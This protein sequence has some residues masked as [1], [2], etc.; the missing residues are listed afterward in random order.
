MSEFYTNSIKF[1][2]SKDNLRKDEEYENNE[3]EEED[4]NLYYPPIDSHSQ[5]IF[6]NNCLQI[7]YGKLPSYCYYKPNDNFN[8]FWNKLNDNEFD[9]IYSYIIESYYITED[10]FNKYYKKT[11]KEIVLDYVNSFFEKE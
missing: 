6:V 3:S 2:I 8:N 7:L 10:D 11:K 5:Y 1:E 9:E 4:D